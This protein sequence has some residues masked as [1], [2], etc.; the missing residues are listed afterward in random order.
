MSRRGL[1]FLEA[2]LAMTLLAFVAATVAGAFGAMQ[3][4]ARIEQE[5]LNA[6]EVAHRVLV[7][8]M[9]DPETVPAP[10][11]FVEQ[12]QGR[13]RVL[14]SEQMLVEDEGSDER[15]SLRRPVPLKQATMNERLGAGLILLTVRVFPYDDAGPV[16]RDTQLVELSRIYNPFSLN[17]F[18]DVFLQHVFRLLGE[19][20]GRMLQ[21]QIE[22]QQR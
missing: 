17:A 13:Y 7:G 12:G 3:R 22:G 4:G 18:T 2:V 10:D 1:T 14:F 21:Q 9:N 15:Y 16:P 5:K 19:D 8:Y 20:R 6:V 11:E